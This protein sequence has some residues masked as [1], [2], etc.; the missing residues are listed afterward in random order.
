MPI[1]GHPRAG[2]EAGQGIVRGRA[3]VL[4]RQPHK[5]G[6]W[7][8]RGHTVPDGFHRL[9]AGTETLLER[10]DKKNNGDMIDPRRPNAGR[11]L[12]GFL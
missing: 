1:D 4:A 8:G 9:R 12:F 6:T 3:L 5:Y 10:F 11:K 2:L 7:L